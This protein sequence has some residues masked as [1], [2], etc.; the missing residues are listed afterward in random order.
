MNEHSEIK[1]QILNIGEVLRSPGLVDRKRKLINEAEEIIVEEAEALKLK[2]ALTIKIHLPL[3]E[4]KYKNEIE[5]AIHMH[6]CYRKE[7]SQKKLKR[8]FHY[9]WR[10]LLIALTLL[11]VI[12]TLS[13]I[14][15][16]LM[17]NSGIA[18]F[19][20]ESFII[21]GWVVL[22]RPLEVLLYDWFPVKKEIHLYHRLENS[23]VQ[24]ITHE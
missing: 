19:V 8:V 20:H 5:S 22:W 11:A 9:G 12:F 2:S 17:P 6:F 7:Q 18:R 14:A 21:L 10:I 1:L 15:L 16:W 3:S 24:F 23:N 4:L 13:E